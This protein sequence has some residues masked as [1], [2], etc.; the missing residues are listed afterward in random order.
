MDVA[1]LYFGSNVRLSQRAQ[2]LPL[3]PF[4]MSLICI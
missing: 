2:Y 3:V 4:D 1:E